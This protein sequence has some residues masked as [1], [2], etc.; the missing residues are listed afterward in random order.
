MTYREAFYVRLLIG[1]VAA[2][3]ATLPVIVPVPENKS[4]QLINRKLTKKT[5]KSFYPITTQHLHP[6][7]VNDP[8]ESRWLE[9]S[10]SVNLDG[11]TFV[12]KDSDLDRVALG[13]P[14]MLKV[15]NA[16]SC[17]L[18]RSEDG[19]NFQDAIIETG[20]DETVVFFIASPK[21]GSAHKTVGKKIDEDQLGS[22]ISC[23]MNRIPGDIKNDDALQAGQW[24]SS[25]VAL[26]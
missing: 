16:R 12:T 15:N 22:Q 26:E 25:P 11:H 1:I 9:P 10:F 4:D 13:D 8:D 6:V 19:H 21:V 23:H 2:F 17:H 3:P 7:F 24:N 14:V 18:D 20:G 5:L